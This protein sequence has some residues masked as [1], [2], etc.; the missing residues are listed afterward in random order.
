MC[1]FLNILSST[2]KGYGKKN[3][4]STERYI[5]NQGSFRKKLDFS[6]EK[7]A[8]GGGIYMHVISAL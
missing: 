7:R 3:K 5:K 8:K 6:R 2:K 4:I 1:V